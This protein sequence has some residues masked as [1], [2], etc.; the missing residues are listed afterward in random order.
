[1]AVPGVEGSG[2]PGKAL[3][4]SLP[5]VGG[6]PPTRQKSLEPERKEEVGR[7]LSRYAEKYGPR[8]MQPHFLFL[9]APSRQDC[10]VLCH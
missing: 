6:L 5:A 9:P 1:M 4:G 10:V 3:W 7:C 2:K 8:H